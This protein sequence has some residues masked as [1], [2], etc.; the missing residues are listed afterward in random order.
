MP[1][2]FV[3]SA[4][5]GAG[6]F[7]AGWPFDTGAFGC[8][9]DNEKSQSRLSEFACRTGLRGELVCGASCHRE[10]NP[11][12]R[13]WGI[14]ESHWNRTLLSTIE[15]ALQWAGAMTWRGPAPVIHQ[16]IRAYDRGVKVGRSAMERLTLLIHR[17]PA[18]PRWSLVTPAG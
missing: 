15:T 1:D 11:I 16:V 2:V 13:C 10:Y 14:L 17:D 4:T 3:Q 18:L 8:G 5:E 7:R 12:E 6:V 9:L